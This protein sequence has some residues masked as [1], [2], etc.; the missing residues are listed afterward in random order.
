MSHRFE[1]ARLDEATTNRIRSLEEDLQCLVVA[2]EVKAPYAKLSHDQ[3]KKLQHIEGELGVS[4]VA[5]QS[6][7]YYRIASVHSETLQRMHQLE[8]DAGLVL[9]AYQHI[10]EDPSRESFPKRGN[11]VAELSKDQVA[12]LQQSESETNLML[13]AYKRS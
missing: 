11:E 7:D 9:V 3:C 10:R 8:K 4:L 12:R 6:T 2:L 1:P 13:M 5:Y